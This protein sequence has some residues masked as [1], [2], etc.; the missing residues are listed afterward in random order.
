MNFDDFSSASSLQAL[1]NL[2]CPN[3]EDEDSDNEQPQSFA[4]MCPGHIGP[5]KNTYSRG[6]GHQTEMVASKEKSVNESDIWSVEEVPE[7][8][9]CDDTWDPREQPEY[10][11][12]FKQRV[13]TEDMFLG[14]SRKD[15][16]TACCEDMLIK[17]KLPDT[18]LADITLDVR[19]KFLDL[20]TPKNKLGL[21]LPHPVDSKNGKALFV[22]EKQILEITLPM[23][24][25]FDLINFA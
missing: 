10:E 16:S 5:E 25:E 24:R 9:E 1:A 11:I 21:H 7:G 3:A 4:S 2:L 18:K 15:A 6:K 12:V 22:S 13:G 14:M 19:D 20:R 17:I 8:S 23:Q